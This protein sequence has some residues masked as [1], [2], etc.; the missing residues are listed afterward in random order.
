M[1]TRADVETAAKRVAGRVRVT[2]VLDAPSE[3]AAGVA[4]LTLKL[5][6]LQHTGSFKPRGVFNRILSGTVGESGVITASGGNAGL[7]VAHAARQLALRAEVFVPETVSPVKLRQL[8]RYGAAVT[9]IGS[10]Y[11]QAHQAS[12]RRAEETGALVVHAYDQPEVAAGQGTLARELERQ[13]PDV[14]AVV[15]A[16]G[17]GGLFA[18][19]AAWFDGLARVIPV[20]PSRCPTLTSALTAGRVVE[21]GVGG[22][23][24][25]SL[26]AAR[27]SGMAL[28]LARTAGAPTVL[29]SDEQILAARQLLWDEF[30]I[31]AEPGGATALAAV[32]SGAYRPEPGERVAVIVCGGNTDP[33][34]LVI[35]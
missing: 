19:I 16:V 8:K 3:W 14:D 11:A 25:G 29:V 22:V 6:L 23:A 9:V 33:A 5:E 1:L 31:A 24:A 10:H 35:P 12:Q 32:T 20:E 17:G 4:P 15:V 28:E 26:G 18:G 7:A 34:D 13:V 2:P 30:R 27:I 21:V